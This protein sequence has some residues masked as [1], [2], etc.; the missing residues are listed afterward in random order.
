M[1]RREGRAADE[2]VSCHVG[3]KGRLG[4]LDDANGIAVTYDNMAQSGLSEPSARF[5]AS[6]AKR[7]CMGM[8]PRS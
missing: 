6:L 7:T 4:L 2:V 3:V 8:W 1:G 5:S